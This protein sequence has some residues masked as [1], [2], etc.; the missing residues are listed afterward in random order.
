[1]RSSALESNNKT[2]SNTHN[3]MDKQRLRVDLE[4]LDALKTQLPD[5]KQF[6]ED[7]IDQE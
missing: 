7:S 6:I 3:K 4:V 2:T 5:A 1:M